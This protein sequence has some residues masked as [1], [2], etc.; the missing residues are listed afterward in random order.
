[1]RLYDNIS[2]SAGNKKWIS[3]AVAADY[4]DSQALWKPSTTPLA[5]G[6][7]VGAATLHNRSGGTV[8]VALAGRFP[9]GIWYA[10]TVT[11]GGALTDDTTDAQDADTA[12]FTMHDRTD[13][14]SGFLISCD[15]PFNCIGVVQSAAGD[16]TTPV[17]IIEYWNGSAWTDIVSSLL[18]SDGLIG[19]STGEKV[20]LFPH[21]SNWTQGGT[22]T[23]VSSSRYNLRV[24]HTH[25]G[26]GTANPVASQI[27]VGYAKLL[28]EGLADNSVLSWIRNLEI[29]FPR[30]CDA[31][32]PVFSTANAGNCVEIDVYE[33]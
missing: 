17:K 14:G 16:Q 19:A 22:G 2:R 27:F 33:A 1:M 25:S 12:D 20:L 13:S 32:F 5:H 6:V 26:A 18:I 21:P 30:V 31:L 23:G 7:A 28:F 4:G 24:R 29:R 15:A 9:V 8:N 10:G 11:S 3:A